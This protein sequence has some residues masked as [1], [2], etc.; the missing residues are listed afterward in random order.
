MSVAKLWQTFE[1]FVFNDT[2]A[3]DFMHTQDNR[4]AAACGAARGSLS[5]SLP[6]PP[7]GPPSCL[8][9]LTGTTI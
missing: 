9:V 1:H 8:L 4:V 6:L 7:S 3:R 5:L 2:E